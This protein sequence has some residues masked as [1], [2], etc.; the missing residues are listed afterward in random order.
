MVIL[1][2]RE[3]KRGSATYILDGICTSETGIISNGRAHEQT[4]WEINVSP[5]T[6]GVYEYCISETHST[7][8]ISSLL[9]INIMNS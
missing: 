9:F 8:V 6:C 7:G 4:V 3:S 5:L 1:D 2:Y